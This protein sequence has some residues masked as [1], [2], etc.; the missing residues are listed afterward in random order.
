MDL[1]DLGGRR[2]CWASGYLLGAAGLGSQLIIELGSE[3]NGIIREVYQ[4]LDSFDVEF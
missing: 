3:C 4:G 2:P 1:A